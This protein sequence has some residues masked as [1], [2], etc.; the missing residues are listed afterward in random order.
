MNRSEIEQLTDEI[1]GE[2][3]L[4][5][6]KENLPIN[7]QGLIRQ[8]RAMKDEA[9][10]ALRREMIVK[11]ISQVSSTVVSTRHQPVHEDRDVSR[12]VRKSKDNVYQ[13][14]DDSPQSGTSKKH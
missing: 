5:L 12:D 10:D 7:V 6:L 13:L 2:A 11:V 9:S 8:L 14:F 4:F 3:V 1:I